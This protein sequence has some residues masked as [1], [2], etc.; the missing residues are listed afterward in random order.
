MPPRTPNPAAQALARARWDKLSPDE[1]K[2]ATAKAR[3]ARARK[4]AGKAAG[5][6]LAQGSAA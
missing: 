5:E 4:R 2:A 6:S 3:A 1:R